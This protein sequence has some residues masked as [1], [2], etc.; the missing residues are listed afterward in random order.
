M[1]DVDFK[2][3]AS[4]SVLTLGGTHIR[5]IDGYLDNE[6]RLRRWQDFFRRALYFRSLVLEPNTCHSDAGATFSAWLVQKLKGLDILVTFPPASVSTAHD[7]DYSQR[8]NQGSS[9]S[10]PPAPSSTGIGFTDTLDTLPPQTMYPKRLTA[11]STVNVSDAASTTSRGHG[12]E[13]LPSMLWQTLGC[14]PSR[15]QMESC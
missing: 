4:L 1:F 7:R 9:P 12:L 15:S 11:R 2:L 14:F 3:R 13:K 10:V 8:G 6:N 5:I